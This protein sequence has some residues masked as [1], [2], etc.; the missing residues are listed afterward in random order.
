MPEINICNSVGRD[1]AV[2][3]ESVGLPL[4]VRWLDSK[5]RQARN[6]RVLKS[7]VDHDIRS[8]VKKF[9]GIENISQAL[10]DGDPEVNLEMTGSFLTS[11]S[12]V[13]VDQDQKLVH[14]IQQFEI[15]K[16]PQGNVKDRRPREVM[17]QNVSGDLPLRWSGKFIK[18][19]EVVRKFV[20]GNKMQLMHIN[21]LT[22]DFLY[23]MARDLEERKSMMLLGGGTK[24]NEPIILRRGSSPYRGFLEGRTDGES[25]CLLLHLSNIEL[26]TPD[27]PSDD[28]SEKSEKAK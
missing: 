13:F 23:G 28:Q 17:T 9:D 5:N 26:K 18:K 16:D 27:P 14:R 21:G 4:R 20:L 25:Y 11:T 7:T 2:N 12:R 8:L 24:G 10:I 19:S 6:I 22:Y 15:I 1:A 3:M